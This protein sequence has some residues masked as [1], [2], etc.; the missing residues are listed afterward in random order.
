[1]K[2]I[3]TILLLLLPVLSL[4]DQGKADIYKSVDS[5]GNV[6]YSDIPSIGAEKITPA[7]IST[8]DRGPSLTPE[9]TTTK[10]EAAK[11][12]TRY[13]KFSILQPKNDVVIWDS[14]GS[15]P[16]TMMLEPDLDTEN[17]HGVWVF[18]DGK[19]II[20]QSISLAPPIS[21]IDRGTH[22][23]RAEIRDSAGKVIKRTK[24]ISVHVKKHAISSP[25]PS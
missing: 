1:M 21:G 12:P 24:M 7:Q 6:V 20:K 18:I 2:R 23:V 19:A 5:H 13:I 22:T 8:V 17:G 25:A 4:A 15:I 11:P 3:F 14:Q 9:Q 10:D 16:L